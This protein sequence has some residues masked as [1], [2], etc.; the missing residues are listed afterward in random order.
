[1]ADGATGRPRATKPRRAFEMIYDKV[2]GDLAKGVLKT[3]DKLP[4]EREL[5]E[6]LGFS[7]SAVREA[8]R[9]LEATGL[10]QLQKGVA[11]GAFIR[12]GDPEALGRSINDIIVLGKIPLRDVMDVRGLLLGRAVHLVCARGSAADI[13]RI[14]QNIDDTEAAAEGGAPLEEHVRAFYS[15]LGE[16]SG[17]EVLAMLID[18]TTSISLNFVFSHKIEFTTELLVLRRNVLA[19][20]RARDADGAARAIS[21][22][23]AFLHGYVIARAAAH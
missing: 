11:G 18:A 19:R 7:R 5:A 14:E 9:A 10:V 13:D 3:G 16:I 2:R 6:Q 20:I 1:M 21:E 4:A 17:N 8:L 23:L 12:G 22:N 15:L